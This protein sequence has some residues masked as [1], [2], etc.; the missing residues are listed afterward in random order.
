MS[1]TDS[2]KSGRLGENTEQGAEELDLLQ[3]MSK[4]IEEGYF[5]SG[6]A[7]E[8]E[9]L[10]SEGAGEEEKYFISSDSEED[11]EAAIFDIDYEKI[12]R[13]EAKETARMERLKQLCPSGL[14]LK[15]VLVV[16]GLI[17]IQGIVYISGARVSAKAVARKM[18]KDELAG[19]AISAAGAFATYVHGDFSYEDGVFKKGDTDLEG[20]YEYIDE[21]NRKND[22]TVKVYFGTDCVMA[23]SGADGTRA[24]D[25]LDGKIYEEVKKSNYYYNPK[26]RVDKKQ[27]CFYV[28]PLMQE[29][30]G[31]TI[32]AVYCGKETA[33]ANAHVRMSTNR[34]AAVGAVIGL[35]SLFGGAIVVL[36]IMAAF[37][38]TTSD[39]EKIA[40][41]NLNVRV[42][43]RMIRRKDEIGDIARA[44]EKL[45]EK[46]N[47]TVDGL[48]DSSSE[49]DNF[50]LLLQKNMKKISETVEGINIAI[51]EIANGATSQAG[52]TLQANDR[53]SEIG[54]A[55][56]GTAE[57]VDLLIDSARKMNDLN[58]NADSTLQELLMISK[59]AD[60]AV[61]E[62]KQQTDKTNLSAQQI[63]KATDMITEIASQTN[64]LSLNASI[65]AARAG[66]AGMGFAV[67]AD[68]IRQLAEQSKSSA[69]EIR[70]IVE[71]LINNS[72]KSVKTMSSVSK[73]IS[74]Q[75]EKL[76][77]TLHVFGNL[78]TEISVVMTAIKE[79]SKQTKGL[80]ETRESVVGIV[81]GLAAIA[82]E[83]AA[84]AQ[85]TSA[86]MYEVESVV[87]ECKKST[88]ELVVL[89][90]VLAKWASAFRN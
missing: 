69:D 58:I 78:G 19:Y 81:E 68:E 83:N 67:V 40:G 50:T 75:N 28:Y 73:S 27:V 37:K 65:E 61:N 33:E 13:Q 1:T 49:L 35:V 82:E 29:S 10:V 5:I 53:V 79:I 7:G 15:L 31:E 51:E 87:E 66:E 71:S 14:S 88:D 77:E 41:G 21:I 52:E 90:D 20:M 12:E 54:D 16:L 55:I 48:T 44:E 42:S 89:K 56:A 63:Q 17:V 86:S 64:L 11:T 18:A 39:L 46:M 45:L 4:E 23:S 70:D 84:S 8:E 85:E 32:G 25:V 22:V 76:D 24:A 36:Q 74:I 9:Q 47:G 2:G 30:T 38:R 59:E 3:E 6:N 72:N 34:L 80:S 62:I 57:E 60:D 43:R 26:A